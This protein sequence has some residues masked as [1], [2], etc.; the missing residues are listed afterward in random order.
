MALGRMLDGGL[1]CG[2]AIRRSRFL[3]I[4]ALRAPV[5]SMKPSI[6]VGAAKIV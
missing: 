4:A 6:I 2:F 3:A 1:D 5:E